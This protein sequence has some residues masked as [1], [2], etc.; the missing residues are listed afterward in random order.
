MMEINSSNLQSSLIL[1]SV[2]LSVCNKFDDFV[3]KAGFHRLWLIFINVCTHCFDQGPQGRL[4][5]SN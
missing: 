2:K 1:I 5:L 3:I 4:D